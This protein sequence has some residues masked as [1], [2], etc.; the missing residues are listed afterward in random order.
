VDQRIVLAEPRRELVE[1]A[2]GRPDTPGLEGFHVDTG[3]GWVLRGEPLHDVAVVD[4]ELAA[5]KGRLTGPDLAG[6]S[7][8]AIAPDGSRVDMRIAAV[9]RPETRRAR[10]RRGGTTM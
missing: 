3:R 10:R 7:F 1:P 4:G 9:V 6:A 8:V 2:R 5:A